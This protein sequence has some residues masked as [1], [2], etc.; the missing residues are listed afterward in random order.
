MQNILWLSKEDVRKT[1][2]CEIEES[3]RI[4]EETFRL[5]EKKQAI[6][7]QESALRT[8]DKEKDQACY[9]MPAYVGGDFQISGIK[10]SAH[11]A[12]GVS[13]TDSRIQATIVLNDTDAG[14]PLSV[15]NGTQ[16]GA[17]RT[18]AV[19]A[20]AL[21]YLGPEM[22]LKAALLGAGGQA[23]YQLRALLYALPE[24]TEIMVW[25]RK[26]NR[27]EALCAAYAAAA[28]GRLRAAETLEEAVRKADIV[29]GATSAPLPYLKPE[30]LEN[31]ALYCHIGFHEI[32]KAAID[33]F[34]KI[35]VDTWEDA[36]H[37]SGQSLFRY[38][39][40]GMLSEERIF[41]TLG[42]VIT[43]SL[44]IP[45]AQEPQKIMFDAFGL[46]IFDLALA[47]TAYIRA[48]QLELGQTLL[49]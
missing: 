21:K 41:G 13:G 20:A 15:M 5:Y 48:K 36:K 9:A 24:T 25:S 12:A 32:T 39:R 37:V 43:G 4:V 40:N 29:I 6:I 49:W 16:I 3:L 45:R 46:P 1:G 22:P 18:G 38:W 35:V 33:G 31:T 10:W 7:V 42:A 30:H 28:P 27:A 34:D 23:E 2:V 47:K 26:Q 17:A 44:R 14:V 8:G 19:T 11:G